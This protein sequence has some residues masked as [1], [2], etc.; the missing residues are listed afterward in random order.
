[1]RAKEF[2]ERFPDES[3]CIMHMRRERE[4]KGVTCQKCDSLRLSWLS[5][6]HRW[7]CMDCRTKTTIRSGTVM[8]HSKLPIQ[9]WFYCMYLM[10]STVKPISA[11]DMQERLGIKRYE[12]VWYMMQKIRIGMSKVNNHVKLEGTVEFD[13]GFFR[14]N[15]L[16]KDPDQQLFNSG[17]GNERRQPV[18]VAVESV[19]RR[20]KKTRKDLKQ[21]TRA[22]FIRMKHLPDY[23]GKTY[24]K[25]AQKLLNKS[26]V[27]ISDANP[28]YNGIKD[29]VANHMATKFAPKESIHAMPWVHIAISNAKRTFLGIYHL[30]S[31]TWLQTYI[32]EFCYKF[33][34]RYNRD[35]AVY[36]LFRAVSTNRLHE[37]G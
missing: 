16:E 29:H 13:D 7:E 30:I 33:N 9:T 10:S 25:L 2:F 17:R 31:D 18:L 15:K 36:K 12:P 37:S 4:A 27:V 19:K 21:N 5:T 6:V 11:K 14:A 1:M 22:G 3:A 28:S 23:E 26:A 20:K 32:D 8:M 35:A 34:Q 24:S